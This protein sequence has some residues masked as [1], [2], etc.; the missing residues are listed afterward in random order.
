MIDL[1]NMTYKQSFQLVGIASVIIA[2]VTAIAIILKP[3]P[4]QENVKIQTQPPDVQPKAENETLAKPKK[5]EMSSDDYSKKVKA[6][7]KDSLKSVDVHLAIEGST[8]WLF[9]A[10]NYSEWRNMGA[11]NRK[12]MVN[13]LLRHMKQT[14]PDDY[15]YY[16]VSVGVNAD[17]PLAEGKWSPLSNGPEIELIGE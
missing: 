10:V 8:K 7:L 9:V 17:Q 2:T 12:E 14:Y 1:K 15:T 3:A 5:A 4:A 6:L 11:I 16:Q 13:L